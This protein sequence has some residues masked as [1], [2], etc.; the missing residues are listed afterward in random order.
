MMTRS[1]DMVM[2]VLRESALPLKPSEILSRLQKMGMYEHTPRKTAIQDINRVLR[3]LAEQIKAI[4][5]MG[6]GG[7][8]EWIDLVPAPD[9]KPAKAAKPKPLKPAPQDRPIT[10]M[11]SL[12][13]KQAEVW[14]DALNDLTY[15][16]APTIGGMCKDLEAHIRAGIKTPEVAQ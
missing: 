8:N 2:Q 11:F 1:R 5:T 4:V 3:E 7:V 12:P 10:V 16:L 9:F 14:A 13:P 15:L 6:A